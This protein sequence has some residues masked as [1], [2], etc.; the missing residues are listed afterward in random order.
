M[1]R[2]RTMIEPA[3]TSWPSPAFTPRRW[4]P[5]SRPFFELEPAFL[6]AMVGYS[7]FVAS[8]ASSAGFF[9]LAGFAAVVSAFAA[10]LVERLEPLADDLVEVLSSPA[11][12]RDAVVLGLAVVELFEAALVAVAFV[13]VLRPLVDFDSAVDAEPS[14]AASAWSAV[15]FL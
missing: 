1:P 5:L 3:C 9:A 11:C 4:P 13:V 2:W 8:V 15:A 14:L 12:V 10:V 6:W 7:S